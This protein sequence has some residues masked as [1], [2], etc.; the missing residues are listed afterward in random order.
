MKKIFVTT[1]NYKLFE[2]YAEKLITSY[3]NT[4]QEIPLY[5][6]VEDDINLYPKHNNI[7]YLNLYT[8]QPSCLKFVERNKIKSKEGAK[9][10]YLLDSVRFSYKVFAQND[11]RKYADQFF[12]IDADTEFKNLIPKNWFNECLPGNVLISIYDRLGYYTEAGFV[13]FNTLPLNN[14]NQKLLDVFFQQYTSYYIYDL[15]YSLPAFTDCHA[16]DATRFRFMLLKNYT[17]DHANYEEKILGNW[18][19]KQDLDVMANDHFINKF[20]KHKKG[21]K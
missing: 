18:V 19:N 8:Q 3:I 2:I 11:A 15:I 10:S 16:L 13:A 5:C 6:Y 1:F 20:I 4:K 14:N 7:F 21:N 9:I 17:N 12:F